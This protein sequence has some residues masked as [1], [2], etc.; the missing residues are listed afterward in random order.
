MDGDSGE[1]LEM[2]VVDRL[3]QLEILG[4][5]SKNLTTWKKNLS[6]N[7]MGSVDREKISIHKRFRIVF[8]TYFTI[9]LT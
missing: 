7:L 6:I 1:Y 2:A 8:S 3:S 9:K 5:L 4:E